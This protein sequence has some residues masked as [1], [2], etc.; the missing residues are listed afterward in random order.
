VEVLDG[1]VVVVSGAEVPVLARQLVEALRLAYVV[2]GRA[3]PHALLEF[4]DQLSRI[5]RG[6]AGSAQLP[7]SAPLTEPGR[8]RGALPVTASGQ[9]ERLTVREAAE[10]AEVSEGYL[11]RACRR[12]DVEASRG[13]P[14]S[15]G[16]LV[17]TDS[18][19]LW[20][21]GRRRKEHQQRKAA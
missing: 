20:I 15:A 19:D 13:G 12:R 7:S 4:T 21:E 3:A 8:F 18:L 9:P 5:A 17:D 16:W 10:R 2:R 6:S 14:G 11:R 1:P